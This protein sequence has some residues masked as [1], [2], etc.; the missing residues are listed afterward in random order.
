MDWILGTAILTCIGQV[1]LLKDS[2]YWKNFEGFTYCL[3]TGLWPVLVFSYDINNGGNTRLLTIYVVNV[4]VWALLALISFVVAQKG[5][6]GFQL[7]YTAGLLIA[8]LS[9][10]SLC[11]YSVFRLFVSKPV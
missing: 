6:Q 2:D 9:W 7:K 11:M 3:L 10:P 1:V 4:V 5:L 8:G